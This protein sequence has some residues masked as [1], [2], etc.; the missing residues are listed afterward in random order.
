MSK[1]YD[2]ILIF[3]LIAALLA[4][5]KLLSLGES[6]QMF[7]VIMAFVSTIPII[8]NSI[9]SFKNKKISID[10][11]AGI[12]LA[13]S[14]ILK[15]WTS[16]IF[17]NLMLSSARVLSEYS[18]GKARSAINSLLKLRPQK[19]KIKTGDKI[20]DKNI[21]E[22]KIGDLAIV[23][24]G[25][26]IAVDGI[27][28]SGNA[29]INQSSLTGESIPVFVTTGSKVFSSTLN[30]AGSIIVRVEKIG[31]DTTLEGIIKLVETAQ[32]NKPQITNIA[33]KFAG[34]FIFATLLGSIV[35]FLI[36]RNFTLLLS[37]LLVACADDIAV[38]VPL[39]FI[40]SIG[41]AAKQGIIIKGGNFLELMTRVKTVIVDKTGTLTR[42]K[43]HVE[44]IVA[45]GVH[46]QDE[47]LKLA[48]NAEYFSKH[49][50][51]KA[52]VK[53]AQNKKIAFDKPVNFM[54]IPGEGETAIFENK[55][56]IAG[57]LSLLQTSGVPISA[58][59][60]SDI[61]LAKNRGLNTTLIAFDN[62]I[63]GFIGLADEVRPEARET[64]AKMRSMGIDHWI[65]LTGDNES[66][67]QKIATEVD[68]SEFHAN[69][70]PEDKL[71][72]IKSHLG[73]DAKKVAMVG[74]GVNDAAALAL[75]DV[76]IAMGAIG[77]DAAIEAADIALM[78]DDFSKIPEIVKIGQRTLKV[79]RQNFW[80]WGIVNII[81]FILIFSK[82]IGPE[83]AAAYNFAT[84][85]IP[86][87]NTFRLMSK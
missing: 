48:V 75:S 71:N 38:A 68:I 3:L 62:E 51:A 10:I 24:S 60:L 16:A 79:V 63:I 8:V 72:F 61:T 78:K 19:V 58:H 5:N 52:I 70:L 42:G 12:A 9:R 49:P 21:S 74:D 69:L 20:V 46:T 44:E 2:I 1:I 87:F 86:L 27:V 82:T 41:N 28:E 29:S 32:Q 55:K 23:E 7:L 26:R 34:R 67:A 45:F 53:Y 64:I 30:E 57:K 76:G 81:G 47:V 43:L 33:E 25:D 22:I 36:F 14:L 35:I 17:I 66:V 73:R 39:S 56:I 40:I 59:Q 50:A 84:D 4:P 83:G 85:F 13:A 15:E 77:T 18:Q 37:L 31:K 6:G 54:E 65:M 80:I 11:L